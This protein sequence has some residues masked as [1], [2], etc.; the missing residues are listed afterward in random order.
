VSYRV[1]SEYWRLRGEE[2]RAIA[3]TLTDE[4]LQLS[5]FVV[6]D[7]YDRLA[8]FSEDQERRPAASWSFSWPHVND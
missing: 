1:S 6:A 5:L 8:E 7:E 4:K 2:T 3:E